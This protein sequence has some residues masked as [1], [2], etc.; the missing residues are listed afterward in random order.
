MS[1]NY[2]ITGGHLLNAKILIVDDSPVTT[3]FLRNILE[4]EN[5]TVIISDDGKSDG[6]NQTVIF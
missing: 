5:H 4:H 2:S 3:E 6:R 1:C